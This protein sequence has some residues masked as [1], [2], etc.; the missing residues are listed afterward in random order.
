[1]EAPCPLEQGTC[2]CYFGKAYCYVTAP[3]QT[4][5]LG[6]APGVCRL[7]FGDSKDACAENFFSFS[8]VYSC[9]GALDP[10]WKNPCPDPSIIGGC[11]AFVPKVQVLDNWG[12]CNGTCR[13]YCD[14]GVTP[15]DEDGDCVG[16][17]NLVG[18]YDASENDNDPLNPLMNECNKDLPNATYPNLNPWIFFNGY[19]LVPPS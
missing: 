1:M 2:P 10:S 17:C 6:T 16:S 7:Q 4:C 3:N 19:I 14:N 18:C 15:C 5:S 13:G 9:A 12:W 11:C 8:H